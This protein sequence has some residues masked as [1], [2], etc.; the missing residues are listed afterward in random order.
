[1]RVPDNQDVKYAGDDPTVGPEDIAQAAYVAVEQAKREGVELRSLMNSDE[2]FEQIKDDARE[3]D[4][5]FDD[6]S[7]MGPPE[8]DLDDLPTPE[9]QER[10]LGMYYD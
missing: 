1:M 2:E 6:G 9:D 10:E 8:Y 5:F 4:E 7:D 3:F